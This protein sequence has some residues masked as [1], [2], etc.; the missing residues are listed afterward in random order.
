MSRVVRLMLTLAFLTMAFGASTAVVAAK[1]T[2]GPVPM[3]TNEDCNY[4]KGSTTTSPTKPRLLTATISADGK[5]ATFSNLSA[6]CTFKIGLASYQVF[7][8]RDDGTPSVSTQE[9][10]DFT[11]TTIKPGQK[12][13]LTVDL[14]NCMAQVDAFYGDVITT[15]AFGDRYSSRLLGAKTV[16]T[17][18]CKEQTGN[19][20]Y[21]P[22]YWKNH[23]NAWPVTSLKL[24]TVTYSKSQ[25]MQILSQ[26]TSTNGMTNLTRQLI[27][28]KL[29][30]ANGASSSSIS[31]AIQQAD[32][33][34]GSRVAPP[35]GNGSLSTSQT[36]SLVGQLDAFNNGVTGPG[37]CG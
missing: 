26:P 15:F 2:S 23:P 18:L 28:A 14:P 35:I 21:T 6:G 31:T 30:I 9:I 17:T 33:M 19:C 20:T 11:V 4:P 25:L 37:H 24:G 34:I 10:F 36:S 5:S 3:L 27:A 8:L 22:G 16:G 12:L 13:T 29:N 1:P 7:N 32:A